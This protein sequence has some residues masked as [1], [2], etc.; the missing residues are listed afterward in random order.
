MRH[1]LSCRTRCDAG[2]RKQKSPERLAQR[3]FCRG[4]LGAWRLNRISPVSV[5]QALQFKKWNTGQESNLRALRSKRNGDA[6]NPLPVCNWIRR[7]ESDLRGRRSE[8]RWDSSNPHLNCIG[9]TARTR[10][11]QAG[12]WRPGTTLWPTRN[13]RR[14]DDSNITPLRMPSV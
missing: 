4:S 8:R 14:A 5:M 2:D 12:F 10:T 13:W 6:S 7:Q 3:A 9:G 11:L 1:S